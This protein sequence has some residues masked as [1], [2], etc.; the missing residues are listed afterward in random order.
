MTTLFSRNSVA[1]NIG[2]QIN[3]M[4]SKYMEST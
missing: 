2:E 4:R 1:R 3:A